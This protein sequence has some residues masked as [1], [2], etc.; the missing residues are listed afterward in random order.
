MTMM[1]KNSMEGNLR[2][3]LTT[4]DIPS[5]IPEKGSE[6]LLMRE[7]TNTFTFKVNIFPYLLK[8][9]T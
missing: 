1:T 2:K 5:G 9:S 4:P 6:E 7:R 8:F 3:T